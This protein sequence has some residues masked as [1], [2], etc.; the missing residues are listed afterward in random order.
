MKQYSFKE[1]KG[2][3]LAYGTDL[4]TNDNQMVITNDVDWLINDTTTQNV[5][6]EGL[7][8]DV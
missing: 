4:M 8:G 6:M 2:S 1:E 7:A 5:L 3:S